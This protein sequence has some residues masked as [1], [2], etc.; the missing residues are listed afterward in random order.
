MKEHNEASFNHPALSTIEAD[1]FYKTYAGFMYTVGKSSG[2]EHTIV[3]EAIDDLVLKFCCERKH[4]YNSGKPFKSYLAAAVRNACCNLC[5]PEYRYRAL[6][7]ELSDHYDECSDAMERSLQEVRRH[8]LL[9]EALDRLSRKV[10]NT[11]KMKV[12]ERLVVREEKPADVAKDLRLD[13]Q[14]IY[15]IKANLLKCFRPLLRHLDDAC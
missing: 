14:D 11:L 15:E 4:S 2:Y 5:R 8:E 12:F 13:I 7:N 1:E 10:R 3:V 6:K 9:R